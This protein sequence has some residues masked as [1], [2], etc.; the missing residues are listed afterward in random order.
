M[1]CS[2]DSFDANSMH[3]LFANCMVAIFVPIKCIWLL[4]R[5]I[6][7]LF[8]FAYVLLF[9]Q[10]MWYNDVRLELSSKDECSLMKKFIWAHTNGHNQ[11]NSSISIGIM[12]HDSNDI[13]KSMLRAAC[14]NLYYSGNS[15]LC[16]H[17]HQHNHRIKAVKESSFLFYI[18]WIRFN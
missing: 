3:T 17:L 15:D 10:E 1:D 5:L 8:C 11:C 7:C 6:G 13:R 12:I 14:A 2:F 4:I 9:S 18:Q 16:S